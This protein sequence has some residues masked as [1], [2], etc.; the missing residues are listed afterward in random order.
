MTEIQ[1]RLFAMSDEK[2]KIFQQKLI[3]EI[4]ADAVIGVRMPQLRAYAKEL[5]GRREA[6]EFLS[7]L[8]HRYY[9]E[10]NLHAALLCHRRDFSEALRLTEEFL[11]YIDNW[12]TC[13]MFFPPVFARH[14]D[15]MIP[16]IKGWIASGE[17]Y[18]VRYGIEALMRMFLDERFDASYLDLV[19]SVRSDEYYVNMMVAW[20][21]ATALAKQYDTTLPYIEERRL[22][23]WTHNKAVQKALESRRIDASAKVHLR[24]LKIP[25]ERG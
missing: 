5:A 11:P 24:K 10:N 9:D 23:S 22:V 7:S 1:M 4:E 25:R 8:P 18:T 14:A 3:P 12:A 15:E 2:Y 17:T 13:D 21:F 6:E 20:F 16:V 19:A